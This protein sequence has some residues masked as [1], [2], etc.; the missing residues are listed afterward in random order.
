MINQ[1]KATQAVSKH[2]PVVRKK[3]C[4]YILTPTD[5]RRKCRNISEIALGYILVS[6]G[7]RNVAHLGE[8]GQELEL[9]YEGQGLKGRGMDHGD[10]VPGLDAQ[11]RGPDPELRADLRRTALRQL[12]RRGEERIG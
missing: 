1:R 10:G 6:S 11:R 3:K 5:P 2:Q 12:R 7:A 8:V 4:L 9:E